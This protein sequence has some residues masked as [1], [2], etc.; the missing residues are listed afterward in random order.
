MNRQGLPPGGA[1]P[2]AAALRKSRDSR[3]TVWFAMMGVSRS[4]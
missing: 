3:E 1:L 2:E 4:R